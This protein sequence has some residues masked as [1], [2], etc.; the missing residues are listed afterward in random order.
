MSRVA[1]VVCCVAPGAGDTDCSAYFLYTERGT[2]Q[3]MKTPV[4]F[5]LQRTVVPL[6][7]LH[8][9]HRRAIAST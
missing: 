7:R 1:V 8:S 5:Y 2:E 9:T 6:Y 3:F 4:C